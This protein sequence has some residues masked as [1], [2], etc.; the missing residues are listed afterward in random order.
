MASHRELSFRRALQA[1]VGK[2]RT[3]SYRQAEQEK[4]WVWGKKAHT[5]EKQHN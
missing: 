3:G 5:G 1:E 4:G 2:I